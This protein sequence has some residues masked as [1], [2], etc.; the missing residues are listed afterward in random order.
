MKNINTLL[1]ANRG[2]IAVRII[3]TAQKMGIKT[4][5][6]HDESERKAL[7]VQKADFAISLGKGSIGET[8][9]NIDKIIQ[10]ARENQV[11]AVHPG[12]GFLSE[13]SQFAKACEENGLIFIGPGPEAIRLMGDKLAAANTAKKI[14]IPLLKFPNNQNN[15]EIPHPAKED[16]PV[17]VKA[18]AGGGGK[19]MRIVDLPEKYKDALE[20]TS[21]EAKKYF[22]D[23]TVYVEKYLANPKHIEIQVLADKHGN[24]VHLFERECSIQRRHQKIIEEAPAPALSAKTRKEMTEAALKIVRELQYT[25]AGTV[26]F[27]VD[28]NEN[29]YFME[30]NTRIQ[31][32]HPVTEMIT[33][34]DIV[35]EQIR[36]AR[37]LPLSFKQEDVKIKGHAVEAR[38]YAEN[39]NNQFLPS[40]G[41]LEQFSYKKLENVRIDSGVTNQTGISADYDPMIAKVTAW[42]E[43]RY[44]A[45]DQLSKALTNMSVTGIK[46]NLPYLKEIINHPAFTANKHT[47]QFINL[48]HKEIIESIEKEKNNSEPDFLLG[49]FMFLQ[50]GNQKKQDKTLWEQIGYWRHLMKL[51]VSL[52]D[53]KHNV[54]IRKISDNLLEIQTDERNFQTRLLAINDDTLKIEIKGRQTEYF[55]S[56][57]S[58]GKFEI[59]W[60]GISHLLSIEDYSDIIKNKKQ[61]SKKEQN[62]NRIHSPMFGKVLEIKAQSGEVVKKGETLL[63]LEAMKMENNIL[64]EQDTKI[65]KIFVNQGDQVKDGQVLI[66]T[67]SV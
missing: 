26:E 11:D 27:L 21:R 59:T 5:A 56:E 34:I 12:Y 38:I 60:N 63:I 23:G 66:E 67:V 19:G 15:G 50:M 42:G 20:S 2:E 46:H 61:Q 58:L 54:T 37:G 4:L 25:S 6:V 10:I 55:Y 52:N 36:I 45:V 49:G 28:E 31:V 65:K 33:G 64:A 17:M 47:T 39:V 40:P 30:M 35:R 8:Y 57:I 51:T 41:K 22:G 43:D 24:A 44:S 9:L 53:R 29:F 14:N 3:K 62:G 48:H 16:F 13:N 7:H 18:S 1:I 32:E